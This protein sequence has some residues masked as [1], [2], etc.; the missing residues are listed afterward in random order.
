[1]PFGDSEST[2]PWR[3]SA[4]IGSSWCRRP[5]PDACGIRARPPR[6]HIARTLLTPEPGSRTTAD[7][8]DGSL[9]RYGSDTSVTVGWVPCPRMVGK[10]IG[11]GV[12][13]GVGTGVGV[14][15]GGGVAVTG[16]QVYDCPVTTT[17]A[18]GF[19]SLYLESGSGLRP[20]KSRVESEGDGGRIRI[21]EGH[22][23]ECVASSHNWIP[24]T[25]RPLES[26]M[27]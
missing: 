12:G 22:G 25:W 14:G 16:L 11:V 17:D 1:M 2:C 6:L 24:D 5:E 26:S 18:T 7:A 23:I 4:A 3:L 8:V 27:R 21:V 15:V 20:D 9:K 10:G 13:V 19:S